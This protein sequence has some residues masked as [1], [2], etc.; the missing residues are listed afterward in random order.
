MEVR[1]S[2]LLTA[3]HWALGAGERVVLLVGAAAGVLTQPHAPACTGSTVVKTM[4]R[5]V[6]CDG[7]RGHAPRRPA[8]PFAPSTTAAV[9]RS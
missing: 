4:S 6:H 1:P 5:M 3:R 2:W 8:Q 9:M 7:A